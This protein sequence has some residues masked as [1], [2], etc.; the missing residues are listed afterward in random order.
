MK[1]LIDAVTDMPHTGNCSLDLDKAIKLFD[2]YC[3]I[4]RGKDLL[5][6]ET[7]YRLFRI[8]AKAKNFKGLKVT[9]SNEDALFLLNSLDLVEVQSGMFRNSTAFYHKDHANV[10]S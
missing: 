8:K 3:V 6:G 2:K 9:I 7:N 4:V 1:T 5:T 10:I